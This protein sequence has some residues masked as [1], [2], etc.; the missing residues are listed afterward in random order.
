MSTARL[1]SPSRPRRGSSDSPAAPGATAAASA[2]R[3]SRPAASDRENRRGAAGHGE[4]ALE[5][6]VG[7]A[8]RQLGG[9]DFTVVVA[10]GRLGLE[11]HAGRERERRAPGARGS[12]EARDDHGGLSLHAEPSGEAA[13]RHLAAERDARFAARQ[14]RAKARSAGGRV[15]RRHAVDREAAPARRPFGA[16]G[17]GRRGQRQREVDVG[18]L[19]LDAGAP[20][21]VA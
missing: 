10:H 3:F 13:R 1:S 2:S 6:G 15:Q 16:E 7:D 9:G 12:E 4:S 5:R 21:A 18:E 19:L 11:A 14:T 8:H 17:A 20:V